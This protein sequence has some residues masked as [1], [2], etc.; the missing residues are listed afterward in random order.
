[1]IFWT[2]FVLW[3]IIAIQCWRRVGWWMRTKHSSCLC[4]GSNRCVGSGIWDY[5]FSLFLS[6]AFWWLIVLCWSVR[7]VNRKYGLTE[8]NVGFFKPTP[9]V[10]SREEKIHRLECERIQRERYIRQLE[11]EAGLPLTG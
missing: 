8:R 7:A 9:V 11:I 4:Y 1:M 2:I 10:E 6:V 5:G 3:T